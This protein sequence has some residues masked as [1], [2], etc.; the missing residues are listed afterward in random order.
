MPDLGMLQEGD[1]AQAASGTAGGADGV[2]EGAALED[3][4]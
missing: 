1:Q 2:P 3:D 4:V